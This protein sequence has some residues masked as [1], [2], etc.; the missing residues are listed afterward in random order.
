M[1]WREELH[2]RDARGRFARKG[3]GRVAPIRATLANIATASDDDLLDLMHRIGT[4]NRYDG[5]ALRRID[6]EL[7]RREGLAELPP[8]EDTPEQKLIDEAV[9]RGAS[10][11]EAFADAY[12]R[13]GGHAGPVLER[14]AGETTHQARR[15]AYLELVSLEALQ[16]EEAT[17][18]HL[19]AKRCIGVEPVTLWSAHPNVARKCATEDLQR[20]WDSNG[21][22]KTYTAWQSMLNGRRATATAGNGRDFGL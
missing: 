22:R 9:R 18:G 12:G 17:R 21:G 20:W 6:A 13:S 1:T 19:V 10:Y 2:P 3:A 15:R 7:A 11:A 8:P 16:A 5:A 4:V 14:R